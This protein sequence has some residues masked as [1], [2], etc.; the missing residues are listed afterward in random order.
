MRATARQSTSETERRAP[1]LAPSREMLARQEL[2]AIRGTPYSDEEWADAKHRLL[3]LAR[4][5]RRW[6]KAA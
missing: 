5:V 1:R 3:A 4:L 2:E 6:V